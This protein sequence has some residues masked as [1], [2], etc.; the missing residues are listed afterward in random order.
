MSCCVCVPD[1]ENNTFS[2]VAWVIVTGANAITL[3]LILDTY[4]SLSVRSQSTFGEGIRGD[5]SYR[6]TEAPVASAVTSQ[7][8]IIQPIWRREETSMSFV[9][10]LP[11]VLAAPA[12]HQQ[13]CLLAQGLQATLKGWTGADLGRSWTESQSL[14]S[15]KRCHL[16]LHFPCLKFS[17]C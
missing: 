2:E 6:T 5:P 15:C 9:S 3:Y 17:C 4:P 7:F 1:Q 11:A 12:Q 13:G 16:P 8:H 10:S 14:S